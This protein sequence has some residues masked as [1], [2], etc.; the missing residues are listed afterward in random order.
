MEEKELQKKCRN[1]IELFEDVLLYIVQDEE[2]KLRMMD[3]DDN[4]QYKFLKKSFFNKGVI[5][6]MRRVI[7]KINSV[8]NR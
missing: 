6:G 3:I 4:D 1:M 7:A 8:A 5:E 2:L